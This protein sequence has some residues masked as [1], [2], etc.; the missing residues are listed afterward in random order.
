MRHCL[1][2]DPDERFQTRAT[3]HST[4]GRCRGLVAGCPGATR[5]RATRRTSQ[6]A[7]RILTGAAGPRRLA[8][9]AGHVLW[10][11]GCGPSS[12][13]RLTFRRGTIGRA[14]FAPD[15]QT[16]VYDARWDG[17]PSEIF[18]LRPGI[19][20]LVRLGITEARLLAVSSG[21]TGHPAHPTLWMYFS[22]GTLARV[23]ARGRG[24]ARRAGGGL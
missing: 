17:K 12:Y 14:R 20:S 7:S 1:A 10:K 2:K 8:F 5:R 9:I 22:K 19:P 6:P 13:Q 4:W 15:G 16:V 24:A 3:W 21:R 23:A 18:T 11:P